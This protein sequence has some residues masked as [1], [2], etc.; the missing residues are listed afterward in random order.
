MVGFAGLKRFTGDDHLFY[1]HKGVY[2][3]T[4]RRTGGWLSSVV[5]NLSGFWSRSPAESDTLS[6]ADA[7][8][9]N[10]SHE[11]SYEEQTENDL[12]DDNDGIII[13]AVSAGPSTTMPTTSRARKCAVFFSYIR[14]YLLLLSPSPRFVAQGSGPKLARVV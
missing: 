12:G 4:E 2:Q 6:G 1:N 11:I 13:E 9:Q 8:S 3:M 5:G 10:S 14:T 7:D